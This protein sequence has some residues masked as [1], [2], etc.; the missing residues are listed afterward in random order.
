MDIV[1]ILSLYQ[2]I[3]QMV[4]KYI[5]NPTEYLTVRKWLKAWQMPL[6]PQL[7]AR[8]CEVPRPDRLSTD[9]LVAGKDT[10]RTLAMEA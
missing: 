2:E 6:C 3:I 10:Y 8:P 1:R 9:T 4:M 7:G 5:K